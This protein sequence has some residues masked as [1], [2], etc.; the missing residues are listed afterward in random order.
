MRSKR[1]KLSAFTLVELLVVITII[2]I[3]ISLLLPAVQA[4]REAARRMQCTNQL[5]QIG[6]ALHNYAQS[7]RVFP[8][9]VISGKSSGTTFAADADPW[10]NANNGAYCHGTSFLLRILPFIEMDNVFKQWDFTTSVIG[11]AQ[12]TATTGTYNHTAAALEIKTF[13][14]P[15]RRS[16]FRSG[17][18]S[19][20][21]LS[22]WPTANNAGGGT[23]FGGC[24]GRLN[25]SA[26]TMVIDSALKTGYCSTTT[27]FPSTFTDSYS[28]CW[29][30]FGQLNTSTSFGAIRD[31]TSNTIMAGELQRITT[32]TGKDDTTR[33]SSTGPIISHDGWAVGGDATLFSTGVP[34]ATSTSTSLM[35]N[36]WF[37]SPGSDHNGT[38]NFGMGDGSVRSLSVSTSAE[39]FALLGS[40]AD[41]LPTTL[42]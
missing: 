3:L 19:V 32:Q 22:G 34:T 15:T 4:A 30:I 14:C 18:D 8:P 16:A 41:C 13:Y 11:N 10:A 42:E 40:M 1:V 5:K 12:A 33:N 24:A 38:V 17:A 7:N 26:Q 36:G 27:P 37:A 35:N 39:V 31:G 29:G 25:W 9:G 23:D 21:M 20:M 6:L 28:K 2:G